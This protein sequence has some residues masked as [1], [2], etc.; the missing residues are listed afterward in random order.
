MFEQVKTCPEH[1]FPMNELASRAILGA[2]SCPQPG[3]D[4]VLRIDV[5][6]KVNAWI[7]EQRFKNQPGSESE[8]QDDER[9]TEDVVC[10]QNLDGKRL[11]VVPFRIPMMIL[12]LGNSQNT[13]VRPS[14]DYSFQMV[15]KR[16][17]SSIFVSI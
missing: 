6:E 17:L 15:M 14:T 3:C 9:N 5:V 4:W 16:T 13:L 8:S 7:F 12:L 1:F 11:L 10:L 2:D